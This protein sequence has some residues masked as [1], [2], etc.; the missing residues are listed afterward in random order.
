MKNVV[1]TVI[2]AVFA[3]LPSY[4]DLNEAVEVGGLYYCLDGDCAYYSG[5]VNDYGPSVLTLSPQIS[6]NGKAYTVVGFKELSYDAAGE[7]YDPL[8]YTGKIFLSETIAN[9]AENVSFLRKYGRYLQQ[10]DV[11]GE[12]RQFSST[13]G[14][15]Y[16]GGGET[17][18]MIPPKRKA[19]LTTFPDNLKT[20][21]DECGYK[22]SLEA[23][24]LPEGV[25]A[26]GDYALYMTH[27]SELTVPNSVT[28]IGANAFNNNQ[29]LKILAFGLGMN[30]L[31]DLRL[32]QCQ[33]LEKVSIS[34]GTTYINVS[35]FEPCK[36][37]REMTVASDNPAYLSYEGILYDKDAKNLLYAPYRVS[38]FAAPPGFEAVPP[39]AFEN[40][41]AMNE[42]Y[43][44]NVRSV[45]E[46]AFSGTS[47]QN[48]DLSGYPKQIGEGAFSDIY[49]G[50]LFE[51]LNSLYITLSP[52]MS[53]I[54]SAFQG[55]KIGSI[56]NCESINSV[57]ES[58]FAGAV[59]L[60]DSVLGI[61]MRSSEIGAGAFYNAKFDFAN[62]NIELSDKIEVIGERTFGGS[63][64]SYYMNINWLKIG[65]N[66]KRIGVAAFDFDNIWSGIYCEPDEPP[67]CDGDPFNSSLYQSATLYVQTPEKYAETA[68]WNKFNNIVYHEYSGVEEVADGGEEVSVSCVGGEMRVE[69]ADG[70]AVTV[71]SADGR[72]AYSG[73]GS[74]TI[75][76]PRGI[77]IVRAGSAT[78]KVIL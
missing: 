74:C 62:T 20:L 32:D 17:M 48:L 22:C 13:D 57:A 8:G 31:K 38:S 54:P 37:M 35:I 4:A 71:W 55:C 18:L 15:L 39:H 65:P 67:V 45:G 7:S 66:V 5:R 68:P 73:T 28:S 11:A 69:C 2:W 26:I 21:A 47:L 27:V 33:S 43:L 51:R 19:A 44:T 16:D 72:E 34:S 24:T 12:S 52:S 9:N 50:E 40:R 46:Y 1:L 59:F 29:N 42:A 6:Y 25:T 75:A 56:Y 63:S 41:K 53:E 78:R 60:D 10:I 70:T 61:I 36:Q 76:L 64:D 23:I 58:A 3:I 77:Y 14:V 49:C 30:E